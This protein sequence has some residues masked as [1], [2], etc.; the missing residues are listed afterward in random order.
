MQLL[1]TY[2]KVSMD[3]LQSHYCPDK[4]VLKPVVS[5][6]LKCAVQILELSKKKNLAEK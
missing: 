1:H 6:I 2:F 4:K 5:D 3:E